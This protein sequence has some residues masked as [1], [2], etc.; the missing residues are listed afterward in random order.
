MPRS[1]LIRSQ[2]PPPSVLLVHCA[3]RLTSINADTD[4]QDEAWSAVSCLCGEPLGKARKD[5]G[6]H[7]AGT[8]RLA[9]WALALLREDEVD[10]ENVE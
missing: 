2:L 6:K 4:T 10:G 9:K 1:P 5:D 7:G 8:L 3:P